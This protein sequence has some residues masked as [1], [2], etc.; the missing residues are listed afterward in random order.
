[1]KKNPQDSTG[2]T[3]TIA[4]PNGTDGRPII[5]KHTSVT[6]SCDQPLFLFWRMQL[7]CSSRKKRI[8]L[9][10]LDSLIVP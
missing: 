8:P 2:A 10:V 9:Q 4:E 7:Y 1:M 6:G 5:R 3:G